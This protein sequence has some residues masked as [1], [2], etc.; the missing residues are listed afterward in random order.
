[1]LPGGGGDGVGLCDALGRPNVQEATRIVTSGQILATR[2]VTPRSLP[3]AA[4]YPVAYPLQPVRRI[5]WLTALILTMLPPYLTAVGGLGRSWSSYVDCEDG[6][7]YHPLK[8]YTGTG[9]SSGRP[10]AETGHTAG[11]G[12]TMQDHHGWSPNPNSSYQTF[13]GTP[14][15]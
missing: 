2:P 10:A 4:R 15:C 9:Y 3:A 14:T 5:A 7:R 11:T 8:T 12:I 6:H 13:Q 1:M